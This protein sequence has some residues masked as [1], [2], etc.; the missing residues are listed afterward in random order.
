M[1]LTENNRFVLQTQRTGYAF[2]TTAGGVLQHLY[3]G[4]RLPREEDYHSAP[5]NR[6]QPGNA[7]LDNEGLCREDLMQEAGTAGWGDLRQPLAE[8]TFPDGGR[9][10]DFRFSHFERPENAG[11]EGLPSAVGGETLKVV[12]KERSHNIYLELYYTVF[13][14]TDVIARWTRIIN[15]TD[16]TVWVERL[17]SQ[18]LDLPAGDYDLVTFRGAWAREMDMVRQNL[19]GQLRWSSAAGISS[20]RCNPF[21]MV[22]RRDA[23]E[24]HGDVWAM[25][26]LYSGDHLGTA[27]KSAYHQVRLTQGM[28]LLRWQLEPGTSFDSPQAVM[29]YS[30][31]GFGGVSR[32]MHPFVQRPEHNIL[33]Y[34]VYIH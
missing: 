18:Q 21:A 27:E 4:A 33:A 30:A 19:E 24:D 8:L 1:I 7:R 9:A 14:E 11:P 22:C 15:D 17:M 13:E 5:V 25:N 28:G 10:A 2:C 29:T 32:A 16:E 26:L 12:L 34:I 20:N 6:N 31:D 3:Y 23:C